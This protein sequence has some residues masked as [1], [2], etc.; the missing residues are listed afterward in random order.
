[1][2]SAA[3]PTTSLCLFPQGRNE[4]RGRAVCSQPA[5]FQPHAFPRA[6][7]VPSSVLSARDT[8]GTRGDKLR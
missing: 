4:G 7:W 5:F 8:V 1:M 2:A 3:Y 6:V